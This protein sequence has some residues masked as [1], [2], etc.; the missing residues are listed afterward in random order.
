MAKP[1]SRL[2]SDFGGRELDCDQNVEVDID[3]IGHY[4]GLLGPNAA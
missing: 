1:V 3:L 2:R 4:H